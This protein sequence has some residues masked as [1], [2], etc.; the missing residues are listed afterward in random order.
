ME[1][2][3]SP[4]GRRGEF[5]G[6]FWP[7]GGRIEMTK[8]IIV[9]PSRR[10]LERME[11]L[12]QSDAPRRQSLGAVFWRAARAVYPS[13]ARRLVRVR[14]DPEVVDWFGSRRD[15]PHSGLNAVLRAYVE[16]RRNDCR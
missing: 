15:D 13:R 5:G 12:T 11:D 8:S 16:G 4:S 14:L 3:W 2:I 7:P 6:G 9:Q 10:R 1:C